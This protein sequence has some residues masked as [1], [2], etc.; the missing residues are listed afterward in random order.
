MSTRCPICNAEYGE[1]DLYCPNCGTPRRSARP[2]GGASTW[3]DDGDSPAAAVEP[4]T[5]AKPSPPATPL[6]RPASTDDDTDFIPLVLPPVHTSRFGRPR[7]RSGSRWLVI[8]IAGLAALLAAAAIAFYV[9]TGDDDE[10]PVARE[11]APT[12]ESAAIAGA[13]PESGSPVS[14]AATVA[15]PVSTAATASPAGHTSTTASATA[16]DPPTAT[17]TAT[18]A[19]SVPGNV[20]AARTAR[21]VTGLVSMAPVSTESAPTANPATPTPDPPTPAAHPS[22]FPTTT[23]GALE[24]VASDIQDRPTPTPASP[25]GEPPVGD[26]TGGSVPLPTTPAG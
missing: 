8:G 11:L 15:T 17:Q 3:P 7:R 14:I 22:E 18:R 13:T 25:S 20:L 1:D 23:W 21:S 19:A 10:D 9:V 6:P 24:S 2:D 26:G 12:S 5:P 4:V 16:E